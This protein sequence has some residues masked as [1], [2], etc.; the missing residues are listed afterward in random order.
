[1]GRRVWWMVFLAV[2]GLAHAQEYRID[3]PA[4]PSSAP[5]HVTRPVEG[6]V[7]VQNLP[8][9]Q[10]VRIVGGPEEPLEVRGDV[11]IRVEESLPVEVLNLPELPARF[12]V[13]GTVRIDDEQPV[14]VWVVNPPP[15]PTAAASEN[16][17]YAA[18]A[19]QGSFGP[20]DTRV[21][22]A[23]RPPEGRVFHLTDLALDART[24]AV[25][26]VRVLVP[27][28]AVAGVVSG[29]G[30]DPLALAVLDSRHGTA[31]RLG[32]PAPLGG[33]FTLEVEA[34]GP[35]QGAP[36][37]VLASGYLSGR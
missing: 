8:R 26:R 15:A 33:E 18:F 17:T 31:L 30:A 16:R 24:D 12:E 29:A 6:R 13:E 7:E 23:L 25:L 35:G 3:R 1:M 5:V 2:V 34:L 20:K 28:G 11:E 36:F 10:D 19:S 32:T 22:Q 14:Q 4:E 37:R 9:V 27:A 21:T